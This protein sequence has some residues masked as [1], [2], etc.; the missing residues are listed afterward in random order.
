MRIRRWAVAS[1][2]ALFV[3]AWLVIYVQLAS[4]HDPALAHANVRPAQSSTPSGSQSQPSVDGWWDEGDGSDSGASGSGSS[5]Q[6][7]APQAQSAPA[8]LTTSQ[9]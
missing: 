7:G 5:D 3:A 6:S 4:G 1:A 8:P 9:S 2:V